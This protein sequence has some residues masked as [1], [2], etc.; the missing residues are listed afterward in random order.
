MSSCKRNVK[1]V[2]FSMLSYTAIKVTRGKHAE[3]DADSQLHKTVIGPHGNTTAHHDTSFWYLADFENICLDCTLTKPIPVSNVDS[4][5]KLF[6]NY[7][8]RNAHNTFRKLKVTVTEELSCMS[9]IR[10]DAMM[11][12]SVDYFKDSVQFL[13][14]SPDI[15]SN[16][17]TAD[18]HCRYLVTVCKRKQRRGGRVSLDIIPKL[19]IQLPAAVRQF[20]NQAL[21]KIEAALCGKGKALNDEFSVRL[22]GSEDERQ[23]NVN[24]LFTLAFHNSDNSHYYILLTKHASA[25]YVCK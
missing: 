19:R 13:L 10:L 20:L 22:S 21:N 15:D 5:D 3:F 9:I 18:A 17:S 14:L 1:D 6:R 8:A 12:C 24:G 7:P 11:P 2:F 4:V 23:D 16:K 25:S